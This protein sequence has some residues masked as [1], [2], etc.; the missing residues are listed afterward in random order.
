MCKSCLTS[1]SQMVKG[2][3]VFPP[4]CW[5]F[6]LDILFPSFVM[7]SMFFR[8]FLSCWY[9]VFFLCILFLICMWLLNF[10][11]NRTIIMSDFHI[12]WG[13]HCS[14]A[15]NWIKSN[16]LLILKFLCFIMCEYVD[17]PYWSY[18][19]LIVQPSSKTVSLPN[20]DGQ[21]VFCTLI[22]GIEQA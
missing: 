2:T 10:L 6:F 13:Y 19:L 21:R 14:L 5:F 15:I 16:W 3:F 22:L 18:E 12:L 8:S 7:C 9:I 11:Y 17:D 4:S 20:F 1:T